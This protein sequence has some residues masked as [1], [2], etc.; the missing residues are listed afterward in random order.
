[1]PWAPPRWVTQ[2]LVC[3]LLFRISWVSI[4]EFAMVCADR[5]IYDCQANFQRSSF[6]VCLFG[7][8]G[9][10]RVTLFREIRY[11][12]RPSKLHSRVLHLKHSSR[13]TFGLAFTGSPSL[14]RTSIRSLAVLAKAK[15]SQTILRR[16]PGHGSAVE[17]CDTEP[18]KCGA[19]CGSAHE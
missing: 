14:A 2:R 7:N 18:P 1:M 11:S 5:H 6:S 9:Q 17:M 3:A 10:L 13:K 16:A 12:L 15:L 8:N 19:G 4:W